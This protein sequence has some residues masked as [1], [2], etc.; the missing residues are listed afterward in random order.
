V[1]IIHTL[2]EQMWLSFSRDAP[3]KVPS[4]DALWE[5]QQPV[6]NPV[7]SLAYRTRMGM[8]R[9]IVTPYASYK[10]EDKKIPCT[11]FRILKGWG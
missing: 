3:T 9:M 4:V 7:Y 2:V 10:D 1:V 6:L 11:P 8:G 5:V